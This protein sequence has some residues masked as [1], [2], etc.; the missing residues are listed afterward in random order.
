MNYV[1][2]YTETRP[3][4][5]VIATR[6][7]IGSKDDRRKPAV[8]GDKK[9]IERAKYAPLILRI[10]YRMFKNYFIILENICVSEASCF[11]DLII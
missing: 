8:P 10:F 9:K 3:C 1:G 4:I 11:L 2:L 7:V 5:D 6:N